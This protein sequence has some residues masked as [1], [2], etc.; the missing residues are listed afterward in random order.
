MP[1]L[2]SRIWASARIILI[3]W[4]VVL[5]AILFFFWNT[6][7][8][9]MF[10]KWVKRSAIWCSIIV[11]TVY[12]FPFFSLCLSV[13]VRA[14]Y[15]LIRICVEPCAKMWNELFSNWIQARRKRC[16]RRCRRR[17]HHHFRRW[18]QSNPSQASEFHM[19]VSLKHVSLNNIQT[20]VKND[21]VRSNAFQST[22]KI[23]R[24]PEGRGAMKKK[25]NTAQQNRIDVQASNV[26]AEMSH[27]SD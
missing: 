11:S 18:H 14:Y 2:P 27:T 21:W 16:R 8:C 13:T 3:R 5:N 15:K 12:E 25:P 7:C 17:C 9:W 19:C 22:R 24:K 26:K 4:N 23:E 20:Y 1:P 6:P 10:K